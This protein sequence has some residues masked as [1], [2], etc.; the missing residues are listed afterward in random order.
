LS[1]AG[2]SKLQQIPQTI[3]VLVADALGM[4]ADAVAISLGLHEGF[5]VFEDRPRNGPETV[6]AA[7]RLTPDVAIVDYWLPD[8]EGPAVTGAILARSPGCKVILLSWLSSPDHIQ[9]SIE[10]GATAFFSKDLSI[11]QLADAVRKVYDGQGG[12]YTKQVK[13]LIEKRGARTG[14]DL[15]LFH[16]LTPRQIEILSLLNI[17][18]STKQIASRLEISAKTVRNHVSE[19]LTKTDTQATSEALAKA[20][21]SG[22]F[23]T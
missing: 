12:L 1:V 10:A 22:F 23:R 13:E 4:F 5:W 15:A 6:E 3:S 14:D 18:Q 16:T 21:R 7:A 20:R 11:D 2:S 17:G 19:V 9:Q 8:M